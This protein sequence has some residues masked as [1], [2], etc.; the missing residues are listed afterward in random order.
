MARQA[1]GEPA[2][3]PAGPAS[4]QHPWYGCQEAGSEVSVRMQDDVGSSRSGGVKGQEGQV[5]SGLGFRQSKC[6]Q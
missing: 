4:S 5:G 6:L 2:P 3:N 1:A